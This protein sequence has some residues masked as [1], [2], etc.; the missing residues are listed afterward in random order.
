MPETIDKAVVPAVPASAVA[1]QAA[2]AVVE[3][4]TAAAEGLVEVM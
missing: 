4:A 2:A 1:V 3:V